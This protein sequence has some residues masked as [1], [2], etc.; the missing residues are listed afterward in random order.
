MAKQLQA[1][2]FSVG[3]HPARPLMKQAGV[4]VRRRTSRR[5]QSPDSRQGYGVAPN[6]WARQFDVDPP[7]VAW[8]GDIP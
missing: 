4:S 3:R 1:E 7:D 2:G 6:E 5:P 8:A